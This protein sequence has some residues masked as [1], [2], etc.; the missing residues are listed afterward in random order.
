M[1]HYRFSISWARIFP[2]GTTASYNSDGMEYYKNLTAE[3]KAN[4]I[5]PMA[6]LYHWDLPQM[7]EDN[8]GWLDDSIVDK[9]N[10]YADKVFEQLG[11]NV[12]SANAIL[13]LIRTTSCRCGYIPKCYAFQNVKKIISRTNSLA[14]KKHAHFLVFPL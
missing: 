10:D 5:T 2:D 14:H 3:L 6:T 7:L 9:F 11:D 12:S 8:G 1:S 13:L 4:N